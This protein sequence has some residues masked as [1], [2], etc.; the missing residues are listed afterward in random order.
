[1]FSAA[2]EPSGELL[3]DRLRLRPP[4]RGDAVALDEAIT[5]T[6]DELALWLPWARL[7][8][9]LADTRRYLRTSR[10]ARARRQAFEF[11]V[12]DTESKRA[13]GMVSLH[14]IDWVRRC[15]GMGYWVRRSEW[16]RGIASEAARAV[17]EMAFRDCGLYRVEVHV[18]L[19]NKASQ[20]VA[21]RA[22]LLPEGVAR[23]IEFVNGRYLD[24]MQYALL[25][26]DVRGQDR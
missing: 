11:L 8:H 3:T 24:H 22:G 1:M 12:E 2:D 18:A 6:I 14:R 16:G 21:E 20:R 25:R 15:A 9:G 7:D 5:E 13:L 10:G 17:L 23:G 4:R 19:E 26:T